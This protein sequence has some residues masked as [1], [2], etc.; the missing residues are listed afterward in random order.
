MV[1]KIIKG[2]TN[3]KELQKE[4]KKSC[5]IITHFPNNGKKCKQCSIEKIYL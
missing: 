2:V 5:N 4:H 3:S 1:T